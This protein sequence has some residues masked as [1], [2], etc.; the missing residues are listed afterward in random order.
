MYIVRPSIQPRAHADALICFFRCRKALTRVFRV[1]FKFISNNKKASMSI[2]Q[3]GRTV[4]TCREVWLTYS[5]KRTVF[6]LKK[7]RENMEIYEEAET[8]V[9]GT[10]T[11]LDTTRRF[12]PQS[13]SKRSGRTPLKP[14]NHQSPY[15]RSL[16]RS[17]M[18]EVRRLLKG[19]AGK[20]NG[21]RSGNIDH[22]ETDHA[23]KKSAFTSKLAHPKKGV[24]GS[25]SSTTNG[26]AVTTSDII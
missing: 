7:Q 8:P 23:K 14:H 22:T 6:L 18:Q 4:K 12:G 20:G 24:V 19:T 9:L 16:P 11:R 3:T 5:S 15:H 13:A 21:T 2:K 1:H 26:V 10:P 17:P 25:K